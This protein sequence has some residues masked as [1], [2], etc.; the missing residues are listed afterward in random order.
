[1]GVNDFARLLRKNSPLV[2]FLANVLLDCVLEDAALLESVAGDVTALDRVAFF[3]SPDSEFIS[4]LSLLLLIRRVLLALFCC[5]KVNFGFS[6]LA[7]R[8]ANLEA[9]AVVRLFADDAVEVASEFVCI[10]LASCRFVI[11]FFLFSSSSDMWFLAIVLLR[12]DLFE[13]REEREKAN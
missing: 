7:D 6:V 11:S 5:S 12:R 10:V 13:A 2:S 4:L 3:S 1:M 9:V 8:A